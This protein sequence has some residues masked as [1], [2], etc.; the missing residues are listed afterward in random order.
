MSKVSRV[1]DVFIGLGFTT[2][3]VEK[4]ATGDYVVGVIG[5]LAALSCFGAAIIGR[6]V[7]A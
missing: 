3:S 1:L 5:A 7:K 4:F 2:I 6:Y